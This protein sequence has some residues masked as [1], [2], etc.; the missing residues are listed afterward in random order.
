M[1]R[2]H[3]HFALL[4][5]GLLASAALLLLLIGEQGLDAKPKAQWRPQPTEQVLSVQPATQLQPVS[6]I[7]RSPLWTGQTLQRSW[8][9]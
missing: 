1:N 7:R 5:K 8:V 9:F 2:R 3:L 6:R 4:G